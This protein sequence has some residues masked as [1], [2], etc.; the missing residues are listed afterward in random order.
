MEKQTSPMHP[1]LLCKHWEKTNYQ[2][3][4]VIVIYGLSPFIKF[5]RLMPTGNIY[6]CCMSGYL[7]QINE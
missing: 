5:L 4:A 1:I 7:M 6:H 3:V 2:H